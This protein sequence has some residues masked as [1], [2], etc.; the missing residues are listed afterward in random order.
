MSSKNIEVLIVDDDKD[1]CDAI[2]SMFERFP[3]EVYVAYSGRE[4]CQMIDD[5]NYSIVITDVHMPEKDGF[6]VL[7][8]IKKRNMEFPKVI[9]ISG[10]MVDKEM[11]YHKGI[12]GFLEKPCNIE[13]AKRLL[14]KC[15]LRR[16]DWWSLP[17]NTRNGRITKKYYD[18][19]AMVQSEEIGLGKGGMFIAHKGESLKE[20]NIYEFK[21]N[22]V[23]GSPLRKIEGQ[24][25]VRWV[26]ESDKDGLPAGVGLEVIHVDKYC[27]PFFKECVDRLWSTCFIPLSGDSSVWKA[28][29]LESME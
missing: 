2:A 18:W 17:V 26:R 6:A 19:D 22:F 29:K 27:L 21:I 23:S 13:E 16:K 20:G 8:H 10:G 7:N 3:I 28:L 4:A 24:G 5:G 25:I 11:A 9:F 12:E 15:L 1:V 14:T